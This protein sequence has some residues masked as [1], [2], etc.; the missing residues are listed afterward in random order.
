M[1]VELVGTGAIYTQYNSACTLINDELIIDMPNGTF[2]QLLKTGHNA[3]KIKTIVVTHL[4]GDHTADI[5]FFLKHIFNIEKSKELITIIG[6]MGIENKLI[7]LFAAYKFENKSE[8]ETNFNIKFI[9]INE[10]MELKD[11]NSYN[12][13]AI[14]VSHGVEKPAYGYIINNKL[15]LTGDTGICIGVEKIMQNSSIMVADASFIKGDCSHMGID[16]IE[17]LAN[18]YHHTIITTHLRDNTREELLIR[19]IEN[20][21]VEEDWHKFQI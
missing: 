19:N 3:K 15:G 2:K 9:E 5:P 13:Q 21:I 7:E 1:N 14:E 6:P 20:V 18:K 10:S 16:N 17:Y 12:I 4:H 11:I 8:I